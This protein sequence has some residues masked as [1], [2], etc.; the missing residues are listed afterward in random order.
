[1]F[2]RLKNNYLFKTK[3]HTV[4]PLLPQK[5]L[6]VLIKRLVFFNKIPYLNYLRKT[7]HFPI[8]FLSEQAT[9][10]SKDENKLFDRMNEKVYFFFPIPWPKIFIFV[11]I[12][13]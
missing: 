7:Q 1:M 3:C 5:A 8:K 10:M 12:I 2:F 9:L 11:F 6:K 4:F 13:I